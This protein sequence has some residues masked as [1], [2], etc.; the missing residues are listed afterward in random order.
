M[1]QNEKATY[2]QE[3]VDKTLAAHETK[4]EGSGGTA[5][6]T[7]S[8]F[9]I[10][11]RKSSGRMIGRYHIVR[12][13]GS[14][15]MGAVYLALDTIL[16]RQVA[17][18]IP[19][20]PKDER[21]P[22]M[23]ARFLREARAG[24]RLRHSHIATVF[25][26]GDESGVPYVAMEFIQGV[27]LDNFFDSTP[28]RLT[29]AATAALVA[30]IADAMQHAHE[31]Q[32]VH[33]DLKPSNIMLL[34]DG[35]P[36]VLDFGLSRLL[37]DFE[38]NVTRDGQLV[39]SPAWM[40]PEQ[41]R[42]IEVDQRTDIYSLGCVL[43][44]LLTSKP[45]FSGTLTAVLLAVSSGDFKKPR[46]I[47]PEIPEELESLCLSMMSTDRSQRPQTM[48]EVCSRI[49]NIALDYTRLN[50]ASAKRPATPQ[51]DCNAGTIHSRPAST[52]AAPQARQLRTLRESSKQPRANTQRSAE[53]NAPSTKA[54]TDA[55]SQLLHKI[56]SARSTQFAVGLFFIVIIALLILIFRPSD[57]SANMKSQFSTP[58]STS[59][60]ML[61]PDRKSQA[62][63]DA[64][65]TETTQTPGKK[66]QRSGANTFKLDELEKE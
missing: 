8:D 22:K 57:Y 37:D 47:L 42:G 38:N 50:S 40:S 20:I 28:E 26:V 30:R 31:C 9:Q 5:E 2:Q 54:N 34:P 16:D 45:P 10:I 32:V 56:R 25:D 24:A 29:P 23:L 11:G 43:Y 18:K 6:E 7:T 63:T 52:R 61:N 58:I 27:S 48:A 65:A 4:I 35:S 53:I 62:S 17:L 33:R 36:R 49:H 51:N 39:G 21:G 64:I 19:R 1:A 15:G 55:R 44:Q 14:G 46:D 41:A 13:L 66:N 12:K 59:P 3:D 60:E